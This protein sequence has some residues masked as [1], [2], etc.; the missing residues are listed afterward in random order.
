MTLAI[1]RERSED[2]FVVRLIG[3]F[4]P[5]MATAITQAILSTDESSVVL[6][7]SELRSLDGSGERAIADAR[8]RLAREGKALKVLGAD[9]DVLTAISLSDPSEFA[10][11]PLNDEP[12][13]TKHRLGIRQK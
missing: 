2:G 3:E 1:H 9:D 5:R 12:H 13:R 10:E 8:D 4:D 6:D 11:Q 7:V